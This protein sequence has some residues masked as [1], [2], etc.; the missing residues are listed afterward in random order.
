MN[1]RDENAGVAANSGVAAT[2][3]TDHQEKLLSYGRR[4][5]SII[6]D[7]TAELAREMARLEIS[8]AEQIAQLKYLA[9]CAPTHRTPRLNGRYWHHWIQTDSRIHSQ[10]STLR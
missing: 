8:V 6:A 2:A 1:A 4:I 5:E 9:E 3:L 10:F 7:R